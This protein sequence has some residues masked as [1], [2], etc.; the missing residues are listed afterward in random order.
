MVDLV[1]Y[2]FVILL[3]IVY[4]R[5]NTKVLVFCTVKNPYAEYVT[6]AFGMCI[7]KYSFTS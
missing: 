1:Y 7:D 6:Y 5:L 4:R 3:N 2:D